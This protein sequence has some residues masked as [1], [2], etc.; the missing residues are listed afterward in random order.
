[1][2]EFDNWNSYLN[3]DGNLLHG[4]IRFCKKGTTDNVAIYNR[5]SVAIRNPEF[6]DM[7]GRTQYQVFVNN[8]DN[9]TAYF[10]QYIGTGDMMQWPDEDYD[11]SRWAYQYSSDNMDPVNTV[12][13]EATSAE[14]VATMADLRARDPETVP[15]VNGVKMLWLYG[16]YEAGDTSP[17]LYVWNSVSLVSDDGG[18]V[19]RPN[20]VSGHGRWILASKDYIFDVRHFGIFPQNNKYSVDYSYTSQL[21]QCATYLS[22]EGLNAW[23]PDY[24]GSLGYYLLDGSNTFAVTGD[25]YVSD[26][27]R[28]I[29]KTGTSGTAIQCHELHKAA[30]GLFDSSVQTGAA[31]LTCDYINISWVGGNCTGNARVGWVID[32]SEYARNLSNTHVKFVTNG[33]SALQLDNCDI[34]SSKKITGP[35]VISNSVLNTSFFA[36]DYDWSDLTMSGNQIL[37]E[38][39]KD[40]NTYILLKNKQGE[41]DYGDLGEQEIDADVRAGGVIENCYGVVRFVSHGATEMH[42]AS[43]TVSGMTATDS[44]NLVDSWITFSN[45][46]V[47]DNLQLRKGSLI[48]SNELQL[49]HPSVIENADVRVTLK[50]F[51]TTLT[52]RNSDINAYVNAHDL[53]LTN[54]QVYS[55]VSQSDNNGVINVQCVGNMF[56]LDASSNPAR[57][58]VHANTENSVVHGIWANNGSSYDVIHW[59]RL[60]RTNLKEQDNDHNYIYAHNTEPFLMKFSGRNHPMRFPIYRGD[61]FE[62]RDIFRTTTAPFVFFNSRTYRVSVVPRGIKWK[63]FSVGKGFIARSAKIDARWDFGIVEDSYSDHTNGVITIVWTWGN[64][65]TTVSSIMSNNRFAYMQM[66]SRDGSG[67]AE[68]D[69]SFESADAD[70]NPDTAPGG[71]FSNGVDIGVLNHAPYDGWDDFAM[72]P[73]TTRHQIDLFVMMDDA[74]EAGTTTPQSM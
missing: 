20:D 52:I 44:L 16:Y 37:L 36:D 38:N 10:Y 74:F 32:S 33:N 65:T 7:I 71:V 42:N 59:I 43:L 50:S 3:N 58:Y 35:I 13:I 63:A 9:V 29:C 46:T 48:G 8:E 21:A 4:K 18:S 39:C 61:R 26:D 28:F 5:D 27:V 25:I 17:V 22:N 2:R 73:D 68:Y 51:G 19:I 11:P 55:T 23:F 6:T 12:N 66:V 1:M 41:S 62:G 60:D 40:A 64:A 67:E 31:T 70:H 30:P 45:A 47:L 69:V 72:Y 24:P 54:N 53:V 34:E 56:H 14:G 15:T 57:H 49:L